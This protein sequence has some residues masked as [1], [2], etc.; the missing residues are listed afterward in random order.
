[1]DVVPCP[2]HK[3]IGTHKCSVFCLY[4]CMY[5]C[6]CVLICVDSTVLG[7]KCKYFL[8]IQKPEPPSL[9]MEVVSL[10]ESVA[11]LILTTSQSLRNIQVS[12]IMGA[13][14][15]GSEHLNSCRCA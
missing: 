13:Y 10:A 2:K 5:M 7:C 3:N 11:Q 15:L 12:W 6:T 4:L 8:I 14:P 1:M 9:L